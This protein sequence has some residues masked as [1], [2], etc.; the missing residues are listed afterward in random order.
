ML[1]QQSLL[2]VLIVGLVAGWL[3][4]KFVRGS[5]LGLVGDIVVGVVGSY[6][7]HLLLPQAGVNLGTGIGA[8]IVVAAI[9]AS[10]LLFL[11]RLVRRL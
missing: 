1:A 6:L 9:G 7:G 11:V 2:Y 8:T 4:A 5:G 10:V 3:A